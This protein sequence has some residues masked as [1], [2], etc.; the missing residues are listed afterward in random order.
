[1]KYLTTGDFHIKRD[2]LEECTNILDQISELTKSCDGLIILGDVFD[3]DNP[4]PDEIQIFMHFLKSISVTKSIYLIGGNH[5][6]LKS[7]INATMWSPTFLPE[8]FYDSNQLLVK[9]EGKSVRMQ[10]INCAESKLGAH[11]FQK[12]GPSFK[13]FKE[14]IVLLGHIHKYQIL[15]KTPKLILHPGA[16]YYIHFGEHLDQKGVVIL[17]LAKEVSY[18]FIPLSVI[19]MN[20]VQIEDTDLDEV[21]NILKDIPIR[22]KLKVIFKISKTS[23]SVISTINKIVEECKNKYYQFKYDTILPNSVLEV[24]NETSQ[25]GIAKLLDS[26]CKEKNIDTEIKKLLQD[27]LEIREEKN[28]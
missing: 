2:R 27:L 6:R 9:L 14:D 25:E 16:P 22:S 10:H 5:G 11:N 13:T 15:S 20:Q 24:K 28:L 8:I 12:E 17:D 26:F 18:E 4:K 23:I 7:N 1:M 19:P 3:N 21:L